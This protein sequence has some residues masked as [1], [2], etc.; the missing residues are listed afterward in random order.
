M[1][2]VGRGARHDSSWLIRIV[3]LTVYCLL[4]TA[5]SRA[6]SLPPPPL[7]AYPPAA[8]AAIARARQA[9]SSKPTDADAMGALGRVLH[10]WEQWEAAR[11]AYG[12]AASRA[13]RAF[14][15][16]YLEA[17]VLQRLALPAA[18]AEKLQVA[19]A[20][21]PDY[22][23]ARLKLAEAVLDAGDLDRSAQ[24]F[25][26]LTDP[27]CAPAVQFGLGRIAA[28]RGRQADAIE[29]FQRAIALYPQFGAAHYAL[30]LAYRATGRR[31]DAQ[32][33]LQ[34]HKE[35]GAQW[36]ALEDPVL[37]AVH[38]VRDDPSAL[39][40]RGVKRGA[41][42][43]VE[44]AIADHEAAV[45]IDPSFAHARANLIGLHGRA[46]NWT[47]A[48]DHYRAVVM[49]GVN[50]AEA[51]YDYG[52]LLGLQAKWDEA[53]DAYRRALALNPLHAEAHNNLGQTLEQLRKLDEAAAAY[54][55]AIES[56]PTLRIARFNLGRMLIA[57]G[58]AEEAVRELTLLTEPRD[59]ETP[60]YLFALATAHVRA[61]RRE[62]G[63][64]WAAEARDL[65]VKFGDTPL[66]AAIEKELARIR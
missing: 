17:V 52:V 60:R 20:T 50:V 11:A 16:P 66:A 38:M 12:R 29:H 53:A 2:Q 15:W 14:E 58:R 28:A 41:A 7:D 37:A 64:K 43:D 59:S 21:K 4:P 46:R 47:K 48:E 30:A 6:Q 45:A 55:R 25:A 57:L 62:D 31:D 39:L 49:L 24:L 54:R 27:S 5:Y 9:A 8:R 1:E 13:P 51:H 18:A 34:R 10:A 42:G 40:Q 26:P 22:L 19:V 61:G 36:P 32:A 35:Y 63:I 65:A 44:G 23:P 33:A 3:L 56:Q